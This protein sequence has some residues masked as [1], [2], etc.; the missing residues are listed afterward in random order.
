M[1]QLSK[2]TSDCTNKD[3]VLST[4]NI[5]VKPENFFNTSHGD[6]HKHYTADSQKRG[7]IELGQLTDFWIHTGTK[8]NLSCPSC[9]EGASQTSTRIEAISYAEATML[10]LEAAEL[11]VKSFCFTGG[12]P[13]VNPDFI[14]ILD[15]ALEHG[16]CLV[17]TNATNPIEKYLP[18]LEQLK[19]K[20]YPLYLR[21]SIDY[22]D[23]KQHD[24]GRG[25]GTF[26]RSLTNCT[27]LSKMGHSVSIARRMDKNE[28]SA[29]INLEF[30]NIFHSFEL[31]K[32]T[33]IVAFPDL[34]I[35][36]TA[37]QNPEITE[38]CMTKYKTAQ[39]RDSFM[40]CHSMMVTKKQGKLCFYPCTLVNDDDSYI[41]GHSLNEAREK[42]RVILRHPRCFACFAHGTSCAKA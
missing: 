38:T 1:Q 18:Q 20:P 9:F 21:I 29:H 42:G 26:N 13:F 5:Q 34:Q 41:Q 37:N 36:K 4:D 19:T 22:P 39:E 27:K 40:C 2:H 35:S 30:Q 23:E 33:S 32:H 8:C 16:S 25:K 24:L 6:W 17:L 10:I 3:S 12:E 7:Y 15:F 31:P 14:N 11:G 28:D